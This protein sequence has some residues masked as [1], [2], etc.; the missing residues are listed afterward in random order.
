[1]KNIHKKTL[2]DSKVKQELNLKRNKNDDNSKYLHS[3]NY[4]N[5]A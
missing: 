5:Y 1:M 4:Y 2:Y 3:K